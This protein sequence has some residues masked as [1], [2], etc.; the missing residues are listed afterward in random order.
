MAGE[1]RVLRRGAALLAL[2]T[3]ASAHAAPQLSRRAA[4][5]RW[6]ALCGGAALSP[7]DARSQSVH[8][9]RPR[10]CALRGGAALVPSGLFAPA[11]FQSS[12]GAVAELAVSAGLGFGAMRVGLITH[13]SITQLSKIVYNLLLP[14]FLLTSIVRTVITYG[15]GAGM[16]SLPLAGAVQIALGLAASN[17]LLWL[18]GIPR[19][20]AKSRRFIVCASFGNSGVLPLLL[21][22][23]LFRGHADPTVLPRAASYISLYLLGWSPVFWSLGANILTGGAAHPSG[24]NGAASAAPPS[25]TLVQT[26]RSALSP[27]IAG[28]LSGL[29]LA[30]IAPRPWLESPR[31]PLRLA[32]TC[33]ANLA[34]AYPPTALLVLCGSLA[35]GPAGPARTPPARDEQRTGALKARRELSTPAALVGILTSA[36]AD[37]RAPRCL[38]R[39]RPRPPARPFF[40]CSGGASRSALTSSQPFPSPTR[41]VAP[42]ADTCSLRA[43]PAAAHL[44]CAQP[45]S[46]RPPRQTPSW[47]SSCCSCPRS[48]RRRTRCSC[49]RSRAT[50]PA[51]LS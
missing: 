29:A 44:R 50:V 31:S 28:A 15:L 39:P 51:R 37:G 22:D 47:P 26:L 27:P 19:G 46:S 8:A 24:A 33:M 32:L 2:A 40:C 41:D 38:S 30:L 3:S 34:R 48:R 42:Q 14:L 23:A 36:R 43:S 7:A 21:T 18:V 1:A 45:A 12:L 13:E 20:T 35:G 49:C 4:D 17:L 6:S 16:L 11:V 10:W 25:R 9:V 5:P